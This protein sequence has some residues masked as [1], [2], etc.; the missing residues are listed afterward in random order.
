VHLLP[1]AF[2]GAHHEPKESAAAITDYRPVLV[3]L[4]R[5]MRRHGGLVLANESMG[6][7]VRIGHLRG[8]TRCQGKS[9]LSR[10]DVLTFALR[11]VDAQ[12]CLAPAFDPAD[13]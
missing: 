11:L 3:L 9:L 12:Q 7:V 13:L 6:N 1:T 4:V 5:D 8:A 10:P 2:G